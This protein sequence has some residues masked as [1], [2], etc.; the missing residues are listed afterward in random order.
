MWS[1]RCRTDLRDPS[2]APTGFKRGLPDLLLL[3][4]PSG[5]R[6]ESL[7][8]R[9]GGSRAENAPPATPLPRENQPPPSGRGVNSCPTGP[10]SATR[11]GGIGEWW[12]SLTP[13][14]GAVRGG[15]AVPSITTGGVRAIA[16]LRYAHSWPNAHAPGVP[17]IPGTGSRS[18][19]SAPSS[20]AGAACALR[21]GSSFRAGSRTC[22]S[23]SC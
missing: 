16:S 3:D 21:V 9:T 8:L 13:S 20:A 15:L 14:A 4:A 6:G 23:I 1:S 10:T 17:G 11:A 19:P 2:G 12:P 5:D 7:P 18:A 22:A